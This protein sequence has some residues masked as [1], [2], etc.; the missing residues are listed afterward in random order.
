[1]KLVV[2]TRR[3]HIP[4]I[5]AQDC[6]A[7]LKKAGIEVEIRPIDT[8]GDALDVTLDDKHGGVFVRDLDEALLRGE[9]DLA[10]HDAKDLG[11]DLSAGVAIAAVPQRLDPRE[12][13]ISTKAR[14][15][16]GLAAGMRVGVS[17]PCRDLQLHRL[18]REV[19]AVPL[20]GDAESRLR[21]L[22]AGEV[23]AVILAA[24][25]L[26][27]LNIAKVITEYIPVEKMVPGVGQGALALAVRSADREVMRAVKAA[28]HHT[29]SG[30]TVR[31][32]RAFL[33]ALPPGLAFAANAEIEP[34]GLILHA[35]IAHRESNSYVADRI[36]G[37]LDDPGALGA[38]LAKK[39]V[40]KL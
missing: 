40:G 13:F 8:V 19:T 39:M 22:N 26:I 27:R 20:A 1:M 10:V 38:Q 23:D 25:A 24:A 11:P 21:A 32:E 6:A 5:Q 2:G 29:A 33:K 31:A 12:A 35:F 15:L 17:G 36:S 3:S 16:A 34:S 9:I 7:L 18:R 28:C 37:E 30:L 4:L 14:K